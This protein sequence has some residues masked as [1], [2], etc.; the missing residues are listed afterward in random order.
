[1]ETPL[2][3]LSQK[4]LTVEAR[5]TLNAGGTWAQISDGQLSC[6]AHLSAS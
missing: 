2:G 5:P 4:N 1:M 6:G 3:G